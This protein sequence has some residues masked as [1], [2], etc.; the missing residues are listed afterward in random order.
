MTAFSGWKNPL[1]AVQMILWD[2]ARWAFMITSP[3]NSEKVNYYDYAAL[4]RYYWVYIVA[5]MVGGILAGFASKFH[6]D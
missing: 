6:F 2:Q 5:P 4:S 1:I 3:R